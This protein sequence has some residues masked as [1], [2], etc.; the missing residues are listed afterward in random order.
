MSL[1]GE[2]SSLAAAR[3]TRNPHTDVAGL[4]R[5]IAAAIDAIMAAFQ[6][7]SGLGRAPVAGALIDLVVLKALVLGIGL[8]GCR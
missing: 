8:Q 1:R 4:L 5:D 2:R 6:I 7:W 3:T